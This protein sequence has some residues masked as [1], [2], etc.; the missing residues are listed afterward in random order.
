VGTG[1]ESQGGG[2]FVVKRPR[3]A[4]LGRWFAGLGGGG[5][6]VWQ[7]E[8]GRLSCHE[9]MTRVQ[10]LT[11]RY[12]PAEQ[13]DE[14]EG[15]MF[16]V[17]EETAADGTRFGRFIQG[18]GGVGRVIWEDLLGREVEESPMRRAAVRG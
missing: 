3:D 7:D 4:T 15:F 17:H 14:G 2:T 13:G 12:L 1:P 18:I 6:V 16:S 9:P 5:K 10:A 11:L 8:M